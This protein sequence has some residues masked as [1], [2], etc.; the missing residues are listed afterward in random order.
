MQ[1]NS[2]SQSGLFAPRV[3]VGFAFCLCGVLLGMFSL[4]ATLPAAAPLRPGTAS[5][6]DSLGNPVFASQ[7]PSASMPLASE[8]QGNWEI[9]NSPNSSNTPT[10][11]LSGVTCVSASNC[12]AVGHYGT[13][14]ADQTL[15]E[16][17]NGTSWTIVPSLNTSATQ[18]NILSGVTCVSASNCWAVGY[19]LNASVV[20]Q[21]LIEHWDGSSWA[22]VT[23]ANTLPTQSN[24]LYGVTCASASNCWAVGYYFIT[25]VAYQSLIERWDGSSWAVVS[26][27]NTLPTQDN[28]LNGVTCVSAS[29][30]WTVGYYYS[31]GAASNGTLIERWNGTSWSIVSSPSNSA[32]AKNVLN[33]VTCV[34]ASNCWAVGSYYTGGGD[35]TLIEHWDGTLWIIVP[36]PNTS[37]RQTN[38]LSGVTCV[39]ASDCW[40]VGNHYNDGPF[41]TLTEH[42]TVSPSPTPTTFEK[43]FDGGGEDSGYSALQ[44]G[45]GNFVTL[46]TTSSFGAGANDMYLQKTDNHGKLLWAKSYGG[47]ANNEESLHVAPTSDGGYVLAGRSYS[48]GAG[49]EDAYLVKTDRDGNLQWSKVYGTPKIERAYSVR[50]TSDGG[51]ILAGTSFDYQNTPVEVNNYE[52]LLIKVTGAGDLVWAKRYDALSDEYGYDVEQTSDGGYI[53]TGRAQSNALGFFDLLLM[54]T[55]GSGN[56]QW[57]NAYG[58]ALQEQASSVRQLDDG[59]YLV[60]GFT[61]SSGAGSGDGLMMKVNNDGSIQ[62]AKNYGGINNELCYSAQPTSDGGYLLA[63]SAGSFGAGSFDGYLVKTDGSGNLQWSRAY[64]GS[65]VEFGIVGFETRDGGYLLA[66]LTRSFS[67]TGDAYLVKTDASGNSG[68]HDVPAATIVG[69]LSPPVTPL[70]FSVTSGGIATADAATQVG[71]APITENTLCASIPLTGVTSRKIHGNA[72]TFD[73]DLPLTGTRGVECRSGGATNDYQLVFTFLNNT[74]V[75]SAS[76]TSGTGTI[77]SSSLGPNPNQYTVNLT[78]VTN[79]QYLTV[80]LNG[81]IDAAGNSN[82]TLVGPQMGVLI[83]DVNASG[84]VTSGDTN[85]CK[86]QA[87]QPVTNANFRSDINESGA[88]TTGDVNLIKQNALS[89]LPAPP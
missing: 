79:V 62:W 13:G 15:I 14:S 29:D 20:Y 64:G 6:A 46:G 39:S 81:L 71:T 44:D 73:V 32:S 2:A 55:D 53:V 75:A 40:A 52:I 12:W 72:G 78:G 83:G 7:Q 65:N 22:I 68:C 23:S 31:N 76:V 5:G 47:A 57:A 80:T 35:Q 82:S 38:V 45:D 56:I 77:S 24:F 67:G 1:K 70:T 89:Q 25:G 3:L 21:S 54:K 26:S 61:N 49:N 58:G 27:P 51:Y 9:V 86:A 60:G 36:S 41:Q 69:V 19:Y 4:A 37:D 30:C 63:G 66:G 10:N 28:V 11:I 59:S 74:S 85:L 8:S 43:V 88:I 87:L 16:R 17:W 34:S 84:V 48:F 50:Q 18:A 42:Y 33:G